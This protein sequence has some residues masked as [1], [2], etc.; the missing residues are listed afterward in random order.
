MEY[1]TN[2]IKITQGKRNFYLLKIPAEVLVKISYVA[3]RGIDTEEGAVQRI[4][5]TRRISGIK[6][7]ALKIGDF[8]T[9]IVLNWKKTDI[10]PEFTGSIIKFPISDKL[11]QL[12]DG[13]HRIE[14]IRAALLEDKSKGQIELPVALYINLNTRECADIFLSINTEQK[15]V[16]QSL[17]FDLYGVASSEIIDLPSARARDIAISL[18]ED[19][20][21]PYSGE[22]KFPGN[23]KK[24]GGIALSTIVSSIKTL[25]EDGGIFEQIG[26]NEFEMQKKIIM[27][28]FNVLR[29][30][31]DEKWF[32]KSNAFLYGSG[33][34]GAI[35]FFE[36]K[37]VPYCNKE[38]SFTSK[39]IN[40][41]I[42]FDKNNLIM[43]TDVKGLSGAK[44]V[45]TIYEKLIE[46]FNPT[47]NTNS[48]KFEI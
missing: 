27:N 31:Y 29:E 5:N 11:C 18:N 12:L 37:L 16:P 30:K 20:N 35:K 42:N 21:S 15:P 43:Q 47:Q 41:I 36:L 44:A 46:T 26:V 8:P 23:N 28:L 14:G 17:V 2:F 9:S 24:R 32:D 38:G 34:S 19:E 40:Q 25:I 6:D 4:L 1:Q 13:Q 33:F 7:Y 22:I 45:N 39:T 48:S 3:T 10:N